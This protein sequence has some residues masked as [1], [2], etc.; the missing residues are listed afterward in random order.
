MGRQ[1]AMALLFLA[2][3]FAV[4]AGAAS[5]DAGPLRIGTS[6]DY[7]PFSTAVGEEV[8]EFEGFDIELSRAYASAR[9]L[10]I[11]FVQFRWP[12]LTAAL[13]ANRFDVAMSGV[14]MRPERSAIGRFSVAVAETGAI[15]LGRPKDRFSQLSDFNRQPVTIGVNAGGH[16]ERIA[17]AQFPNATLLAI[18]DNA[19]VH[20]ALMEGTLDAVVT[21]TLEVQQWRNA[22]DDLALIGPFTSDRKAYLVRQERPDLAADLDRW[23][24]DREADGTLDRLRSKYFGSQNHSRLATPLRA[25]L[26]AIDERLSLMPLVGAAKRRAGL[27]LEAPEREQIVL[28]AA[29]ES[30]MAAARR[31]D[32]TPPPKAAVHQLF[33]AQMEAAKE[34]Q[35]ESL[36]DPQSSPTDSE[37]DLQTQLRPALLRIGDRIGELLVTLPADLDDARVREVA[38]RELRAP[39][40]SKAS[41]LALADAISGLSAAWK[42]QRDRADSESVGER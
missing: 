28:D 13:V 22:S 38:L 18:E 2:A 21:D 26:T 32:L 37:F 23:L 5:G 25:L 15:V 11:E 17:R 14:T 8:V 3:A 27:P 9:G 34:V 20:T 30:V 12:E 29:V 33:V 24:L 16:L 41:V 31:A 19:A 35:W 39:H 4:T 10:G 6:G 1:T 40:L 7:P 36:R 42:N